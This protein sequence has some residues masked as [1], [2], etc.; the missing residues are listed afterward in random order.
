MFYRMRVKHE[1]EMVER[2]CY[3]HQQEV[4][5]LQEVVSTRLRIL[6]SALR[7]VRPSHLHLSIFHIHTHTHT[8]KLKESTNTPD[9]NKQQQK[10]QQQQKEEEEED[11]EEEESEMEEKWRL[12][13]KRIK[14]L[15]SYLSHTH[16]TSSEYQSQ[17]KRQLHWQTSLWGAELQSGGNVKFSAPRDCGGNWEKACMELVKSRFSAANWQV[18]VATV[19]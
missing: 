1:Q 9:N 2:K 11:E 17:L 4:R 8:Q 13:E 14:D 16:S 3:A 12:I 6:H 18:G 10:Q 15:M 5:Q 19:L 7:K